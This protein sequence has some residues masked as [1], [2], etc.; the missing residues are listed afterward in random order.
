MKYGIKANLSAK[1]I[2]E[3]LENKKLLSTQKG[4]QNKKKLLAIQKVAKKLPRSRRK[5]NLRKTRKWECRWSEKARKSRV[6]SN[7]VE[8]VFPNLVNS[9]L[10]SVF[11]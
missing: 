2:S 7:Y 8:I 3:L 5:R 4:A 10:M 6:P 1:S 11:F 9:S